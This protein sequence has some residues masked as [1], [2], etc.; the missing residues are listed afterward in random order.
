MVGVEGRG[1]GSGESYP[2]YAKAIMHIDVTEEAY[3]QPHK[4]TC[5]QA[6]TPRNKHAPIT[7]LHVQ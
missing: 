2:A 3:M 1:H 7:N 4:N 6:C 5:M